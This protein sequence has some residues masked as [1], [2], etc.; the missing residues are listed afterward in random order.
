MDDFDEADT[1]A[2]F[3]DADLLEAG[4]DL[5]EARDREYPITGMPNVGGEGFVDYVLWG[6]DGLPLA[7]IEAK[8]T[9]RDPIVGQQQA[10]LYADALERMT[11]RRPVIF[12]S[13]GATHHL[14]DDAAGYP[15]REV[16]GFLTRDELEL[17][18]QRRRTR[19]PLSTVPVNS[20]IAG[21]HYQLRAVRT[22]DDALEARRRRALLVMTTGSGKTRTII[23]LVDQLMKAGW[24]KRVLFLAD[25]VAL[26]NQAAG[27]F[28]THL[29]DA[30][31][32]NLVTE[33]AGDGRVF[34]ATYPTIMNLVDT[35]DDSGRRRFGPGFFD[36]VVIDE[37]HRSVYAKYHGGVDRVARRAAA[38]SPTAC[39]E[40]LEALRRGCA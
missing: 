6:A 35:Y 10:K 25:R 20:T 7:I 2:L 16:A 19:L 8:R 26:V 4:W 21:R 15:P 37:A 14:W 34:V 13:N 23:A 29:P 1:R 40:S 36:L 27:A 28:K 22:I 32:V 12:F 3:I 17:M 39:F 38:R 9:R 24:V 18:I 33:K 31:T 11:G 30:A 5:G